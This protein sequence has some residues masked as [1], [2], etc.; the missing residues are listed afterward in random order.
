MLLYNHR[1]KERKQKEKENKVMWKELKKELKK[2]VKG[3]DT[4]LIEAYIENY[5]FH[6]CT[7]TENCVYAVDEHGYGEYFYK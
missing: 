3:W 1:N 2:E 7:R 6:V 4:L 5:G